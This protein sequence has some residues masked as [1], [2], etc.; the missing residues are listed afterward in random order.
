MLHVQVS[1]VWT[2]WTVWTNLD[3]LLLRIHMTSTVAF[4]Y[5]GAAWSAH[6]PHVAGLYAGEEGEREQA[7]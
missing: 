6:Q 4:F 2:V 7:D 3:L 5:A 1:S